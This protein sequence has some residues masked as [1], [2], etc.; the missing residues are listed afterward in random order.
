MKKLIMI[1]GVLIA[2]ISVAAA[3]EFKLAK[4]TG[5]LEIHLGNVTVEGHAGSEIIFTSR[6]KRDDDDRDED[7]RSQGLRAINGLGLEDNTALGINVTDKGNVIEVNQ[8]KK[9]NSPEIKILVPKGV[10]VSY[11]YSSQYGGDATFKNLENEIEASSHYNSLEFDNVT[12]PITAKAIYGHIEAVF[13]S[14]VKGPLSL[15]SVYGYAD[16]TLPAAI[17]ANLKLVTSYGEILVAPEFKIEI[18]KDG[19]MVR[20]S[21]RVNGKVNGGGMSVDIRSDYG[22][23][24]LRKK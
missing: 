24:Y 17:K 19:D 9:M 3:Q 7:R 10:I 16:V 18:D 5:R 12:G 11:E 2:I 13:S 15:V 21:D 20:Y 8:L 4:A 1:I 6:N 22:K 23:V 14:N